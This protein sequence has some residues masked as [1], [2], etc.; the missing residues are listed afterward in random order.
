MSNALKDSN[1]ASSLLAVLNTDTTQG[2]NL[3]RIAVDPV[4]HGILIDETATISFTM[5]P[6][7]PKDANSSEV[8]AF[9]GTDHQLYP[10]VATSLG[11]LLVNTH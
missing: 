2:T 4:T 6:I 10:A 9:E 7:D 11:A 1:S 5:K 3:V 8:W